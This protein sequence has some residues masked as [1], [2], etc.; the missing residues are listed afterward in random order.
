MEIRKGGSDLNLSFRFFVLSFFLHFSISSFFVDNQNLPEC[1]PPA[2][3]GGTVELVLTPLFWLAVVDGAAVLLS[4]EEVGLVRVPFRP[5]II[6]ETNGIGGI[7]R[8]TCRFTMAFWIFCMSPDRSK[9]DR[10]VKK[11]Q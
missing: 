5:R 1:S 4:D 7:R 9:T 10:I 6:V 2:L 8:E 3:I 11:R